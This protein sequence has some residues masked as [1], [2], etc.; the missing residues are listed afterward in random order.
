[1]KVKNISYPYPVLGNED[2]VQGL[3]KVKFWHRLGRDQIRFRVEF[4]LKNKTLQSLVKK[5]VVIFTVE[6]ECSN[7]FYRQN[8]RTFKTTFDFEADAPKMREQVVVKFFIRALEP[9]NDYAIDGCHDDYGEFKFNISKGDV[10]ALGGAT[11]FSADKEFDPLKPAVS[12]FM[13]VREDVN[14][15]RGPM[16]VDYDDPDKIIIKLSKKDWEKYQGVKGMQWVAPLVHSS[17]VLSVLA[18]AIKLVDDDD[19]EAQD[20]HWFKRL[21]MIIQRKDLPADIPLVAAQMILDNP[22]DR[23]LNSIESVEGLD[24]YEN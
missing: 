10:L 12:S 18:D 4:E 8:F 13:A 16:V 15:T 11:S 9:I 24:Q 17:I 7:T 23:C 5:K 6:L 14:N 22:I 20:M 1:M 21:Q 2:D 3:F 19:P